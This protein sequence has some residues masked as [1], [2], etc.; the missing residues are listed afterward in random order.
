[1]V[2]VNYEFSPFEGNI[3]PGYPTGL[4]VYLQSTK[5]IYKETN[6][7]Y[8]SVKDSKVIVDHFIILSNNYGWVT[9]EFMV[10]TYIGAKYFFY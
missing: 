8:I 3:Y 4:K 7:L 6:R 10:G 1:M 9:L 5:D 2:A